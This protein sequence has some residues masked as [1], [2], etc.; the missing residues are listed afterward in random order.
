MLTIGREVSDR[1]NS[2]RERG[3]EREGAETGRNDETWR[4]NVLGGIKS[5]KETGMSY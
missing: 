3:N 4:T 1:E 2:D 5:I